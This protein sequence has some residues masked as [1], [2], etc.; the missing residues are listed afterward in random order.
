MKNNILKIGNWKLKIGDFRRGMSYVELIVVLSIFSVISSVVIFNYG[1][2]QAKI[3]IKNLA[4]D[5]ALKI[6]EAQKSSL[7]GKLP[8]LAQQLQITSVWKPSYGLYFN[9]VSDN[10]SFIYFTDLN[11]NTLYEG[12]DCLD[13]CAEKITLN[14]ENTISSLDVLYQ[15]DVTPHSFNDLT[16]TFT[17]PSGSAVIKSASPFTS[18]I[19]YIQTTVLS[20]KGSTAII[21]VYP[22]GRI[23]V[24]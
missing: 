2:F 21:K 1:E 6:V 16:I 3:D 24:N 8:S 4:G 18:A 15:G 9:I 10:K 11:N 19:S 13:E 7:S 12:S 17:R 14:K 20:P 23:Q 5:I 22:S